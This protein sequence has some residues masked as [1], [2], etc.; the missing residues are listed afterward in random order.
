MTSECGLAAKWMNMAPLLA[1][2]TRHA[3]SLTATVANLFPWVLLLLL[4]PTIHLRQTDLTSEF[5]VVSIRPSRKGLKLFISLF[6]LGRRCVECCDGKGGIDACVAEL[7]PS[8]R[9]PTMSTPRELNRKRAKRPKV[10]TGC[11]TCKVFLNPNISHVIFTDRYL[12][13]PCEM[14]R[15]SSSAHASVR[16]FSPCGC[17]ACFWIHFIIAIL[18]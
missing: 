14:R 3:F 18:S 12:D 17:V 2:V 8:R 1:G 10:K 4:R 13:T 6:P 16:F 11:V 7:Q 5:V 9:D 15:G